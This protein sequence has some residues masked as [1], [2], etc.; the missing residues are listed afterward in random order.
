MHDTIKQPISYLCLSVASILIELKR[1]SEALELIIRCQ[2]FAD[3][4]DPLLDARLKLMHA[5]LLTFTANNPCEEQ[6]DK[7]IENLLQTAHTKFQKFQGTG[8]EAETYF[9]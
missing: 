6:V 2:K 4:L 5:S 9:V 1:Y 8:E 7:D 3:K